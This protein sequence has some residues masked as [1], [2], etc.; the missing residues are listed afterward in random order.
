M[1]VN[2]AEVGFAYLLRAIALSPNGRASS[3]LP[4]KEIDHTLDHFAVAAFKQGVRP[5]GNWSELVQE[6]INKPYCEWPS[7]LQVDLLE[8]D[9]RLVRLGKIPDAS[10][11]ANAWVGELAEEYVELRNSPEE[12]EENQFFNELHSYCQ[13]HEDPHSLYVELRR[14]LVSSVSKTEDEMIDFLSE[15]P[16][17]LRGLIDNAYYTADTAPSDFACQQCGAPSINS[18]PHPQCRD[19]LA[20][21]SIEIRNYEFGEKVLRGRIASAFYFRSAIDVHLFEA[22]KKIV[23]DC[24]LWPN[25]DCD[26]D[27]A[28]N[29]A[30]GDR[31]IFDCKDYLYPR[32]LIRKVSQERKPENC[33]RFVYVVPDRVGKVYLQQV[34]DALPDRNFLFFSGAIDSVKKK[35]RRVRNARS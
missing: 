34:R 33:D 18:K 32:S 5:P 29:F 28:V 13:A 10:I 30:N 20:M 4:L 12:I 22:F 7:Y 31:W 25:L 11:Q 23:P 6:V 14:Y 8:P 3:G 19:C 27:V 2:H 24:D 21:Q 35:A 17:E 26:G 16:K 9:D 1:A 15:K